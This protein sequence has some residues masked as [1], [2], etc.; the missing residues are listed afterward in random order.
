MSPINV[1]GRPGFGIVPGAQQ[2]GLL[3]QK[4]QLPA[5]LMDLTDEQYL[6]L[7]RQYGYNEKSARK[8]LEVF[9]AYVA[10][11]QPRGQEPPVTEGP[12]RGKLYDT[13]M[14][15]RDGLRE[16]RRATGD[17]DEDTG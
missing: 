15:A 9:R 4:P 13:W 17:E 1:G 8:E 3:R 12:T 10:A 14:K 2:F 7:L 5:A 11:M 16:R 6:E